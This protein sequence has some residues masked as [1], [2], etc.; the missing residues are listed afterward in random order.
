MI[1]TLKNPSYLEHE[2]QWPYQLFLYDNEDLTPT[3]FDEMM[4]LGLQWPT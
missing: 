4:I 3:K 2:G 1:E